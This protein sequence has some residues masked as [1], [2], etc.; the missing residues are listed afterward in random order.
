[1]RPLDDEDVVIEYVAAPLEVDA[2]DEAFAE[3]NDVFQR[4]SR[5]E[6]GYAAT[7]LKPE[8]GG[9]AKPDDANGVKKE[10]AGE[11]L[12]DVKNEDGDDVDDEDEDE[13]AGGLSNRARKLA[14]RMKIAELKQ[15]CAKPEVVEVWDT[16]AADPRLL[17]YLKAY[18]NTIP[19]PQHWCQKRKF[20]QGKRGLEKPPWQLPAFIEATG[21]QKLR[22]AYAEKEEGKKL[23]QKTKDKTTAK[24]GK[25]DIDYQVLHDAFFKYQTKPKM[26][27]VGE[28]YYEGKEYE[29]DLKGK[30]PGVLSEETRAA[31]GMT[32]DGPPP[33]LINM[34]RYGPPPSYPNLKIPGLSAPIPPGAQFGYHPGGWGKPPVDEYGNPIYGDVFGVRASADDGSTPYDVVLE[35]R[36]RWGALEELSESE[37][38]DEEEEEEESDAGEEELGEEEM[39]AGIATGATG[40]ET[41]EAPMDLRKRSAAPDAPPQLYRVL[42]AREANVADGNIMGSSHVY[43][44]PGAGGDVAGAVPGETRA[45]RTAAGATEIALNPED[46]EAGMDDAAVAARYEAEVAARRAASAPE[47]F[48]DMVAENARKTK[49]KAEA[50]KKESD[51]K[52]FKF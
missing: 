32:E 33:W 26:T 51:A 42:D 52:K 48:S 6:D 25:I 50:K 23:K 10:E 24:M 12:V 40:V 46:L 8:D 18:R 30:K 7:Y 47:D 44:V 22:D 27:S 41:P 20:L 9:G 3:L 49:R 43:V 16:T 21:I 5:R 14:T 4:F 45:K 31:L 28:I 38:E 29:T 13:D 36:K 11:E 39:A 37:S 15:H 17:V 1:M 2:G 34:Q 19:V 35:R